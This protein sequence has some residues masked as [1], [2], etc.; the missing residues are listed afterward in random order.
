MVVSFRASDKTR[1]RSACTASPSRRVVR[2]LRKKKLDSCMRAKFSCC[3]D[4]FCST[5]LL[6]RYAQHVGTTQHNT[7]KI[8]HRRKATNSVRVHGTRELS[9]ENKNKTGVCEVK[10]DEERSFSKNPLTVRITIRGIVVIVFQPS[11]IYLFI[12]IRW[13]F[14]DSGGCE[15]V[16]VRRR[17]EHKHD[18]QP[19]RRR[20]RRSHYLLCIDYSK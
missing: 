8:Y 20:Q 4:M 1:E 16:S 13:R 14:R 6:L 19:A 11:N 3:C 17:Q 7:R 5:N 12:P 9:I 2:L 10:N 15:T 18:H